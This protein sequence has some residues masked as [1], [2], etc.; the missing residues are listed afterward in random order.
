MEKQ[1]K[2]GLQKFG[3][4][5]V[6]RAKG[7]TLR[8]EALRLLEHGDVVLVIDLTGVEMMSSGFARELFGGMWEELGSQF[9]DRV[10]F[11][12]GENKQ[13]LWSMIARGLSSAV[14]HSKAST[15]SN[16]APS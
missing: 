3:S 13:I 11:R 10:V 8:Q 12:F 16:Y 14:A 1:I 15:T 4:H 2:W 9:P 7:I 6:P 5:P